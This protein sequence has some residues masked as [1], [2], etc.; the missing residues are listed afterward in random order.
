MVIGDWECLSTTAAEPTPRASTCRT[1]AEDEVVAWTEPPGAEAGPEAPVGGEPGQGEPGQGEPGQ[2]EAGQGDPG[3]I[4]T[5]DGLVYD[6]ADQVVFTTP[7]RAAYCIL[8]A[9]EGPGGASVYC[10]VNASTVPADHP[11]QGA[12][13]ESFGY[14]VEFLP[15]RDHEF[16]CNNHSNIPRT[17]QPFDSDDGWVVERETLPGGQQVGILQY[18]QV[19]QQG[20]VACTVQPDGL[21]C[22]TTDGNY[23][24]VLSTAHYEQW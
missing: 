17:T 13:P 16:W 3:D 6:A 20:R 5:G 15:G 2:G 23:G 12:C 8:R 9:M 21:T 7:G 1:A 19:I 14:Y 11:L 24:F 18:G 10:E 4:D 22:T